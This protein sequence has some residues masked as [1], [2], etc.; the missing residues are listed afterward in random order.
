VRIEVQDY[1]DVGAAHERIK[2]DVENGVVRHFGQEQLT[3][4]FMA[5]KQMQM[6]AKWKF[7]RVSDGDDIT[8]A[9]A[10]AL[11]LRYFD[12]LPPIGRGTLTPVA[13]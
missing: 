10:S 1:E 11:A 4:A 6:G 5:V 3:A 8:P 13:V 9:Q 12:G 2:L 7:G